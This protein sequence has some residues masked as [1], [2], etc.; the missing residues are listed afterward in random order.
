MK[1]KFLML[2]LLLGLTGIIAA[3]T[4]MPVGLTDRATLQS[5]EFGAHFFLEYQA[6]S[7]CRQ[8]I[9]KLK[10]KIY[11]SSITLVLAT[12]CHD[13]QQQVPRFFKILDE[14]DYNTNNVKIITVDKDKLAGD[15]DISDLNIELVPTFIFHK[16][17]NETGRIIESPTESLEKDMYKIVF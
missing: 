14:L 5:G 7:P 6:Y 1:S 9:D 11:T 4:E 13:S 3:Q 2:I 10:N 17:N 16:N 15:V 12:W 8:T